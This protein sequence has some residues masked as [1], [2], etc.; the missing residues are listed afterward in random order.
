MPQRQYSEQSHAGSPPQAL[1][2]GQGL[3]Q[4]H[5]RRGQA[6]LCRGPG[7]LDAEQVFESDDF[8]AQTEQALRNIVEVLAEAGAGPEHIVRLTWYVTSKREY[9]VAPA[10]RR[11]RLPPRAR[12]ALPRHDAGAGGGAGGRPRQGRDRGDGGG[13]PPAGCPGSCSLIGGCNARKPSY[14]PPLDIAVRRGCGSI[15]VWRLPARRDGSGARHRKRTARSRPS[16][17]TA[18]IS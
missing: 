6:D 15:C 8:A 11:R 5:R 18:R 14:Q 12:P 13:S 1:G 7:G 9:I 16:S 2:R 4:R 17:L 3:C 10:R